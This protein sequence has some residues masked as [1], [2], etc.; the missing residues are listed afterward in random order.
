L[1]AMSF[2][3]TIMLFLVPFAAIMCL[4][5][6]ADSRERGPGNAN[7]RASGVAPPEYRYS[8]KK[9][10]EL[11]GKI[12]VNPVVLTGDPYTGGGKKIDGT[13]SAAVGPSSVCALRYVDKG[14]RRYEIK[15][16]RDERGALSGGYM[17]THRG[18]CGTCSTLKD[19]A[20][21]L[22]HRD[23]TYR[24]RKC[25]LRITRNGIME[26]LAGIGFTETC[27]ATWYYNVRNTARHCLGACLASWITNEPLNNPDG[28][29]N[30]CIRCDEEKSGPI[31]KYCAGRT[32]RNSG[33]V[34]EIGRRDGEIS[35]I[36][37]DY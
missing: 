9:I 7:A 30:G 28:S 19:L 14:R 27:A 24:V 29:L 8:E 16:F 23:L 13:D 26:C 18:P 4:L 21:Y 6:P 37:H 12:I 1:R 10:R 20:A 31:F 5:F 17:I 15:T 22:R 33:I 35:P 11:E 3:K 25:S 2:T 34:S 32:R 36:R